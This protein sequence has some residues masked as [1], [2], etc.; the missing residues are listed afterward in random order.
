[1]TPEQISILGK[2]VKD[3]SATPEEEL[4]L[5]QSLN[6]GVTTLRELLKELEEEKI[7]QEISDTMSK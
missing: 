5:L 1:M 7:K 4:L 6:S 3:G 2:K